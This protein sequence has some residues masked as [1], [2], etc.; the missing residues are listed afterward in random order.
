MLQAD[1]G[2]HWIHL[3]GKQDVDEYV[4]RLMRLMVDLEVGRLGYQVSGILLRLDP[5][6]AVVALQLGGA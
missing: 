6:T 2:H 4:G 1:A 3:I 5:R